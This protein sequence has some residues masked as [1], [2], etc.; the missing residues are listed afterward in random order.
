MRPLRR[1]WDALCHWKAGKY[2]PAKQSIATGER[3][4]DIQPALFGRPGSEWIVEK[5]FT[6]VDGIKH[7]RV[8]SASDSTETRVLSVTVLGDRSRFVRV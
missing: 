8:V 1:F 7:A 5:V 4:R 2:L 3:Y 6:G